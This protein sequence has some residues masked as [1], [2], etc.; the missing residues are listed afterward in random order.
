MK[1]KTAEA[2]GEQLDWGVAT[3]GALNGDY[4]ECG[5]TESNGVWVGQFG[6]DCEVFSHT[7]PAVWGGLIKKYRIDIVFSH[8]KPLVYAE[9]CGLEFTSI[10][11]EQTGESPEQAVARIVIAMKLGDEFECPDELG[12]QS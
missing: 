2:T 7:D 8:D 12:A 1:I 9:V 6:K 5:W 10:V 11:R 3:V 4:H